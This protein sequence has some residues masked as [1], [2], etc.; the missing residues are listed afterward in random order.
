MEL[1]ASARSSM[2]AFRR[3]RIYAAF[4]ILAMAVGLAGAQGP[5]DGAVRGVV[6]DPLGAGVAGARVALTSSE[7]GTVRRVAAG[8]DGSFLVAH[9]EPGGYGVR[10]EAA[11]FSPVPAEVTVGL[12]EVVEVRLG[13]VVAWARN[14]VEVVAETEGVEA[15]ESRVGRE[16][17][18]LIPVNGRRW[19]SV[20]VGTPGF[21]P[22]QDGDGLV[23][24]HGL[25]STQNSVLIDGM[26]ANQ[27]FGSV[28][29]G[30][31][32]DAAAEEGEEAR[33]SASAG[34]LGLAR[35]RAAGAP[36]SFSQAAVREFRVSGRGYTALVGHAAGGVITT[37]SRSGTRELH[38]SGFGLVRSSELAATSPLAVAT[39][40]RNGV[41]SAAVVKPHDL[42]ENFGGTLGGPVWRARRLFFFYAYDQQRRGYPAISSPESASF[43][44][45][46]ATQTALLGNR[47]V[48]T[49]QVGAALTY[50][51][52]LTGPVAR[53]ADETIHF[54]RVDW[55]AVGG[56]GVGLEYNRVRWSSPAGL[57]DAPVVARGRGSL[58]DQEGWLDT[59]VGS[60]RTTAGAH[61]GNEARFQ[62]S[63]DLQYQ[64]PQPNLAQ[65]PTI[66]P[67]GLAPE[68]EI[69]PDGFLFG[70]PA[71]L[72][73]VAYPDERRYQGAETVSWGRG[74]H[75]VQAGVDV[76]AVH[77]RVASLANAA[78]TFSYDSSLVNGHAGGLVDW[79]TDYT[80]NVRAYPNGGCPSITAAVHLFCFRSFTQ[81]FGVQDVAF[82]TQEWAGFV[83][84]RW[85]VRRGLSIDAGVR[86]EY[87]LLPFPQVRNDALDAV[88]GTQGATSVFP[89]DR[90]NFGPRVGVA[91]EPM[92]AGRGVVRVGYGM[93]FGRV[94]GATIRSALTD[95]ALASSTRHIRI[96]PS[97]TTAC[98]QVANQGFGYVCAYVGAPP[99][100]IAATTRATVFDRRFR[101]P[102]VQQ[103][104]LSV[105]R[106]V[107]AGLVVSGTYVMNLDRQLAGSTDLNIAPSTGTKTFQL[108]GGT[109]AVGVRDGERFVVPVY[110]ARVSTAFGPVTD[111][112]SDVNG[113]YQALQVGVS[114]RA[115]GGL[116]VR[117][118]YGWSKAL[119][120]GQA[121]SGTPRVNG[122]F[123]PFEIRYD[124]SRSAL[125][126]PQS[127]H[128]TAV[129]QPRVERGDGWVRRLGGG[130]SVAPIV[131]ARSGRP[132][133][134]EIFGGTQLSGGRE[135]INGSGGAT[136]LPTVGRN[137]LKLLGTVNV[138][139]R[140]VRTVTLPDGVRLRLSAEAFNLT[141]RVNLSSTT[142]RAFLVGTAVAGVTP[143]IF[144]DAATVA[145][146][147]LNTPAFGTPT[148]ASTSLN[149]ERQVQL[150]VHL[151]F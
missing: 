148:S 84:E 134:L 22:D 78:G 151:D 102:V 27:S 81:G 129:W 70:T 12:G 120:F 9:V 56:N 142:Q 26:E 150:G 4:W 96:T 18:D 43:F 64:R 40:Y 73:K 124:K 85:Q 58:G 10:A 60:M 3:A 1:H 39:S 127:V 23:S 51:S 126:Y 132:Y 16:E 80:F 106:E 6:V 62:V 42:R 7:T 131:T 53:R 55:R 98:P 24:L 14:N 15:L 79:I 29:L 74:R 31:G 101:T 112:R 135:S 93:F 17:L 72:A 2:V 99:A 37:V 86:Y 49:S 68:V 104:S 141:N 30:T 90:N 123:D 116:T 57:V 94:A 103:A 149:R 136:Y 89:E 59:V 69:A 108:Q 122:Q 83:Q 8:S 35:G 146:E 95:T 140:V 100:A 82:D 34:V 28:P 20:A 118:S 66:G 138:D 77:D 91:W 52:S 65:E 114:R 145:A 137:T 46:S 107:G 130:W 139:L 113:T 76:S 97:T 44:N 48:R 110:T 19:Q 25:S 36:S 67:G 47:G 88:F 5:V 38:G 92:G 109:G 125:N 117:A 87:E 13:V 147:G 33:G 45:L 121:G 41:V 119:D 143:L 61:V 50:L 71:S 128:V 75:L 32:S 54:G 21:E 63:R 11:G 144:Q 115:R 105:E 111:I 133:T